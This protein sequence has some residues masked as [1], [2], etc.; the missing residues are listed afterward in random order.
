MVLSEDKKARLLALI[1]DESTYHRVLDFLDDLTDETPSADP[2]APYLDH[3]SSYFIER[4]YDMIALHKP[5]GPLIYHNPA[6]ERLLGYTSEE[7]RTIAPDSLVHPDDLSYTRDQLHQAVLAGE[8]IAQAE[9]RV[10]KRDGGVIWVQT[11]ALPIYDDRGDLTYLLA[12]SRD[13][14]ASKHQTEQQ[15]RTLV[16]NTPDLIYRYNLEG[17]C[18]YAN[19]A[20][21]KMWGLPLTEIIG[22]TNQEMGFSEEIIADLRQRRERIYRTGEED[23]MT[24]EFRDRRYWTRLVPEFDETGAVESILSIARDM[25]DFYHVQDAL[26]ESEASLKKA[27]QVGSVGSWQVNFDTGENVWSD[28]F[29]RICGLEPGNITPTVELGMSLIHPEDRPRAAEAV[30]RSQKTGAPYQIEKR[31]VRPDGD[32]RWVDSRGEVITGEDGATYLIGTFLDI[33]ERKQVELALRQSEARANAL[34]IAI[35]DMVLQLNRAGDFVAVYGDYSQLIYPPDEMIGKNIANFFEPK[36]VQQIQTAIAQA[37]TQQ[38]VETL[39]YVLDVPGRGLRE[40]EARLVAVDVDQVLAV[41]RD[42]SKSRHA[43]SVLRQSEARYRT[44]LT[45]MNEGVLLYDDSGKIVM[46]NQAAIDILGV[47]PDALRGRQAIELIGNF[48]NEDAV[49]YLR[50]Q[51]PVVKCLRTNQPQLNVVMT[52]THPQDGDER[53]INTNT[54]PLL[55]PETQQAYGA[56]ITFD[57][58]TAAREQ[59]AI[60][61][62]AA[63]ARER[64]QILRQFVQMASHEFRMPLSIITT[65]LHMLHKLDEASDRQRKIDR[66]NQ[67]ILRLNQL[68]NMQLLMTKLDSGVDLKLQVIPVAYLLEPVQKQIADTVQRKQIDLEIR[69]EPPDLSLM[70]DAEYFQQALYQLLDNALTYT[71]EGGHVRVVARQADEMTQLEIADDGIGLEDDDIPHLF[72]HFWRKDK[73]HSKA[74]FGLGLSVAQRIIELH[75]GKIEVQSAPQQ[76]STFIIS[77]PMVAVHSSS[78]A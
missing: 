56:I 77:V 37:L 50:D 33:T 32:I 71:D 54:Q 65:N 35:P 19:P 21:A 17:R 5:D 40:Y 49:V 72:E 68:L 24:F 66:I 39:E 60:E 51:Y 20:V 18:L 30:Q 36:L 34:L 27:Q 28:E 6:F 48:T 1:G 78:S 8:E 22:K 55:D 61:M 46:F 63:I 38:H 44:I 7:L 41:V 10:R 14:T 73:A 59:K 23:E 64:S 2:L 12:I 26:I 3:A 15:F 4:T 74:G 42:V 25:T 47:E 52:F 62:R 9:Y 70:V 43:Q 76:G 11:D 29:F 16:E 67:Q 31:I 13:I 53:W 75:Q 45:A 58:I 69:V 57:D